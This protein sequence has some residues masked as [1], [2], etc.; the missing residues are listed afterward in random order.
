[1]FGEM[2]YIIANGKPIIFSID[3]EHATFKELNPTSAG[4]VKFHI[5]KETSKILPNTYGMS[6]T[7]D[8]LE[9]DPNDKEII[10]KVVN[11]LF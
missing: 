10:S 3:I 7:L 11:P 5:C 9:S 4:F 2:K 8:Q 6:I 1:M